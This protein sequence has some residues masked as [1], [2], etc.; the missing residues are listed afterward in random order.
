[1]SESEAYKKAMEKIPLDIQLQVM[2][3]IS[4]IEQS[5]IKNFEDGLKALSIRCDE[6]QSGYHDVIH[7]DEVRAVIIKLLKK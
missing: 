4:V 2:K 1:M 7:I 5:H 3:D 6:I